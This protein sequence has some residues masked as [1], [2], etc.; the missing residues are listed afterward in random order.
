MGLVPLFPLGNKCNG[1]VQ[2][3]GEAL[4]AAQVDPHAAGVV[5]VVEAVEA[6]PVVVN[7]AGLEVLGVEACLDCSND[8]KGH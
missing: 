1:D 3:W 6:V 7:T 4:G 5:E 8:V 2:A